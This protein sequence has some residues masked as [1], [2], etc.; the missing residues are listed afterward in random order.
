MAKKVPVEDVSGEKLVA[1][2]EMKKLCNVS[3]SALR[4]YEKLGLLDQYNIPVVRHNGIRY[5]RRGDS[6]KLSQIKA[7]R[8]SVRNKKLSQGG[9]RHGQG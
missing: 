4:G 1:I 3:A 9:L 7:D 5:F 2:G 8:L 6:F